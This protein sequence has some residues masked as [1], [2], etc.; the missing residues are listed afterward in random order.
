[1]GYNIDEM[2][3]IDTST[4][5]FEDFIRN[6]LLY[7]DKS[8]YAYDI[9][10]SKEATIFR[11]MARPRRFGKTLFVSMLEAALEGKRELFDG[12]YL[13]KSDYDFHPYPLLHLDM[14]RVTATEGIETFKS[15]LT[16]YIWSCVRKYDLPI[17]RYM[18][19][20]VELFNAA[21]NELAE[22]TGEEVCVLIDECD[23]ILTRSLTNR[24]GEEIRAVTRGLY[25]KLKPNSDNI[26]FLFITGITRFSSQSIFSERNN[27]EDITFDDSYATAFGYTQAELEKY[28][29]EGIEESGLDRGYLING[30]KY[31]YDGYSFAED[32]ER[33]YNPV[34][35]NS[36][37][38]K[39]KHEFR[40]YW[41]DT[42]STGMV[43]DIARR[44]YIALTPDDIPSITDS[45][46]RNFAVENF[47]QGVRIS[48][49]RTYGYLYMTGYLTLDHRAG[50]NLYLRMPNHEVERI[51]AEVFAEAFLGDDCNEKVLP[52]FDR[53]VLKCDA[54]ALADVIDRIIH[55]PAYDMRM[56]DERFYHALIYSVASMSSNIE[57]KAEEHTAEGRSDLVFT[58]AGAAMVVELKI[59]RSADEALK[60]IEDREYM[61]KYT[62]KGCSVV[63]L[64]VNISTK[65]R[66]KPILEWKEKRA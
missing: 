36:F 20:P 63:L 27:L 26:H 37:F 15:S 48:T 59:N 49:T 61:K 8:R 45:T 58:A 7:V 56:D 9:L 2:K 52:S 53:A 43:M 40:P 5:T 57:V 60:Q 16:D 44:T 30:L 66:K 10:S 23:T 18:Y 35:I 25:S 14:S 34:S 50:S 62:D 47:A 3:T 54:E 6:E 13:G 12:L 33:V 39:G 19:S 55:I 24:D 1:M 4:S 22:K 31:W 42:A 64:G 65:G 28:F 11:F 29:E 17:E 21:I 46:L 38:K 41:A 51:M 32:A